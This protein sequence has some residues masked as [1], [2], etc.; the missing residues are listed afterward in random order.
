MLELLLSLV[1]S[2]AGGYILGA[3]ASLAAVAGVYL[4]GRSA[5]VAREREK[6]AAATLDLV[7]EKNHAENDVASLSDA[8]LDAELVHAGRKP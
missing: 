5:G 3:L 7:A 6:T 4:K 8:A 1:T 2:K